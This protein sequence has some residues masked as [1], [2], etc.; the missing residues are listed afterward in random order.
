NLGVMADDGF[1]VNDH[2]RPDI[3]IDAD[4]HAVSND[5]SLADLRPL[6]AGGMGR[7]ERLGAEAIAADPIDD[8]PAAGHALPVDP[9]ER[10]A[11]GVDLA[12]PFEQR[13]PRPPVGAI[14]NV[15]RVSDIADHLV[16][17]ELGQLERLLRKAA[18]T[19][20]CQTCHRRNS[21]IAFFRVIGTSAASSE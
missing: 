8:A 12:P 11:D 2:E 6:G 9:S 21:T 18:A 19:N 16:A 10:D 7:Y 15:S 13:L 5:G 1:G 14:E 17:R 20:E 4:D 3:G